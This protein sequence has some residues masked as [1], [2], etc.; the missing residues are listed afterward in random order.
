MR[1]MKL[2]VSAIPML[3][4]AGFTH[5]AYV[6]ANTARTSHIPL[7]HISEVPA[8]DVADA[9]CALC[10][11][12]N[13]WHWFSSVTELCEGENCL[14]NNC[15]ACGGSS[16]CHTDPEPGDCHIPCQCDE[17]LAKEDVDLL[18]VEVDRALS[19]HDLPQLAK[20]IIESEA[21]RFNQTRRAVQIVDCR[22][23]V[24]HIA[25]PDHDVS[26]L[27]RAVVLAE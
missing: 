20:L 23:V 14:Q 22:G 9:T 4:V 11:Y 25:L 5:I 24:R 1:S 3:V 15:R 2:A 7:T 21:V 17:G 18:L 26:G 12:Y 19:Q 13:G 27:H 10:Y 16:D 6:D 8:F